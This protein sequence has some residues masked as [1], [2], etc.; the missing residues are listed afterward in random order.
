MPALLVRPLPAPHL[1]SAAFAL[2]LAVALYCLAYSWLAGRPEGIGDALGWAAINVLPWFLAFEASKR[3]RSAWGSLLALTAAFGFSL[4]LGAA[5]AG[6]AAGLEFEALRR[7]PA[8]LVVLLLLWIGRL[9][10]ALSKG[11]PFA[12]ALLPLAPDQIDRIAAAG[13][14]VEIRRRD[15][16]IVVHRAPLAE[17]EQALARH[18]FV[19]IHRSHLVR[20]DSIARV[21]PADVILRDGTSLKTGKRFRARLRG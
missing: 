10:P 5:W 11:A 17:V 4:G 15:G 16:G 12:G 1:V 8:L 21:R 3:A 20:R 9:R 13:N 19:R 2:A 6:T 7:L 18:G 14:Y